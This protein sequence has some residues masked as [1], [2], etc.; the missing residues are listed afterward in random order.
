M[1]AIILFKSPYLSRPSLKR[2]NVKRKNGKKRKIY[3]KVLKSNK[4]A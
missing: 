2:G 1:K 3:G 4:I